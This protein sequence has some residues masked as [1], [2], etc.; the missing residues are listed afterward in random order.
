MEWTRGPTIGR[1]ASA[2][3]SLATAFP[4]GEQFAVKTTEMTHSS[5]LQKEQLF[6]AQ[7]SSP[8]IVKYMGFDVTCENDKPMYNL[9]MEYV[10]GGALSDAIKKRGGGLDESIISSY[11]HQI[12]Q[13]LD[14]LHM[15]G[16]VHCDIKG[17]NI[18][19]GKDGLKIADLGCAR[20]ADGG[21]S[22]STLSGTP[23][24]MAP[25]VAR[26]EEQSFPADIWALGCTVIEMATGS[27][28]WPEVDDPVSALYRIGFSS[29]VPEFPWWLS[30]NAKS[31]LCKC[32]MRDPEERWTAKQLLQ[33]PFLDELE[34][35]LK[36][37]T[38]SSPT[39]VLDQDLWDSMEVLETPWNLTHSTS[40]SWNSPAERIRQLS[41]NTS[42]SLSNLPNWAWDENWVTVRS[43]NIEE[44][45]SC[46]AVVADE[47]QHSA[48]TTLVTATMI[49][50]QE[51]ESS[52]INGH[53]FFEDYTY[54]I[55]H[56]SSF[57]TANSGL[58]MAFDSVNDFFVLRSFNFERYI[59]RS[60]RGEVKWNPY[61]GH[62][63]YASD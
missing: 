44:S 11:A 61:V 56:T 29:E 21:A 36:E 54:K 41:A 18:L 27:N 52:S 6:L 5:F 57:S 34:P 39:T 10:P 45:E 16:V 7:L 32:L 12:V 43:N 31:F 49:H 24:F 1:G 60:N 50:E 25:E 13:G 38:M 2:T 28:P 62:G 47:E 9:F 42:S 22:T 48:A 17:S 40:P 53:F 37:F 63:C 46:S 23:L 55:T 20:L 3:V 4:S 58:V 33:H 30:E 51:V 35:P 14:Y 15:K 26:G 8:H 19:V 59:D